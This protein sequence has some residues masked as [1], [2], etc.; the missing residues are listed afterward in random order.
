MI[1]GKDKYEVFA[2]IV[3]LY[4]AMI[5][6]Y[7]FVRWWKIFTPK[8]MLQHKPLRSAFGRPIALLPLHLLQ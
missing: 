4:V 1:T 7:G 5:L 6:A 2:A 8:T 3:P